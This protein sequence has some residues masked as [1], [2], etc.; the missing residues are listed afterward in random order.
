MIAAACKVYEAPRTPPTARPPS[1]PPSPPQGNLDDFTPCAGPIDS[2]DFNNDLVEDVSPHTAD[3]PDTTAVPVAAAAP[4]ADA[5]AADAP[6]ATAATAASEENDLEPDVAEPPPK[7]R[8]VLRV[9]VRGLVNELASQV[10]FS[11]A[12]L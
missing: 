4:A 5:P 10:D 12:Q 7:R 8:L 6:A 1:L 2:T 3:L 11:R 9:N